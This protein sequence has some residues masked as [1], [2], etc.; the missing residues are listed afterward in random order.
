MP[1][2]NIKI[3]LMDS[4]QLEQRGICDCDCDCDGVHWSPKQ[5]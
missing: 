2:I 3:S 5:H 1:H 4:G